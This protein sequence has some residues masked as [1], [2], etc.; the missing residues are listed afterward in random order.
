MFV[1]ARGSVIMF[2]IAKGSAF[3]KGEM[4][5]EALGTF[6]AQV[7]SNTRLMLNSVSSKN[8]S[9]AASK[10]PTLQPRMDTRKSPSA[11]I[12][13]HYVANATT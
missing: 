8:F 10:G 11:G 9:H 2:H 4:V 1:C 3:K 13:T 7:C 12:C 5:Y 6:V